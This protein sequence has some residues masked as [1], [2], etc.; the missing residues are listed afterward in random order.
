[1]PLDL[2]TRRGC[3]LVVLLCLAS[4]PLAAE[5]YAYLFGNLDAA[6]HAVAGVPRQARLSVAFA[7][8]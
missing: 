5:E 4:V 7:W 3:A 2:F 1:M 6:T 8:R